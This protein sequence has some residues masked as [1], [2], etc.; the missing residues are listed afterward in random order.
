MKLLGF[1]ALCLIWGTTWLAIK[2]SVEGIPPFFCAAIRFIV[3]A[4]VLFI[5]IFFKK[6]SLRINKRE[7][8][9]ILICAILIYAID[10]AFVYWGEQYLSAGVTSIFF[11]TFTLF[12]AI[13]T[14]FFFRSEPF[15][16]RKFTGLLIGFSG[17]LIVFFDQLI[18]TQFNSLVI[19]ASI[20]ITISA[21][22]ASLSV[23]IVKNYLTKMNSFTLTFHQMLIG[24]FLLLFLS[25]TFNDVNK[26]Q[27]NMKIAAAIAYLSILG[28]A[29]AFVLYY[30]LLQ[31]MSAITLS[32]VIYITPIVALITDYLVLGEVIAFRSIIG[33]VIVF[34]GIG[35]TQFK[36]KLNSSTAK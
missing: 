30:R 14:I 27:I 34:S 23:V 10:Y 5:I 2:V 32:L 3:A 13:W 6:V 28:S 33:M 25:F 26:I 19:L 20:A 1:I 22:S 17:I 29:F 8:W 18:V 12:T 36:P 31:Q 35:L 4:I 21:A 24:I 9:I 11:S 15:C 7:F 16:W